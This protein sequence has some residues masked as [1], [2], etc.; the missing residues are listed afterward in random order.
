MAGIFLLFKQ[1]DLHTRPIF[2]PVLS[3]CKPPRVPPGNGSGRVTSWGNFLV[4]CVVNNS[5]SILFSQIC[6]NVIHVYIPKWWTQRLLTIIQISIR[7]WSKHFVVGIVVSGLIDPWDSGIFKRMNH[8][9]IDEMAVKKE[10]DHD[11]HHETR[12]EH[13]D[14]HSQ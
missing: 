7:F 3:G 1:R 4:G 13:G 9:G 10:E 8:C 6:F 2:P 14:A 12:D 11:E 5:E